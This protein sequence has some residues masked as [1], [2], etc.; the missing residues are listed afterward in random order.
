MQKRTENA[1]D[2]GSEKKMCDDEKKREQNETSS[3]R[4]RHIRETKNK[5]FIRGDEKKNERKDNS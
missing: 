5:H 1:I 3:H 4:S 2:K